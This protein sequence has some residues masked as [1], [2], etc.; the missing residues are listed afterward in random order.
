MKCRISELR[1]PRKLSHPTF[2]FSTRIGGYRFAQG[3]VANRAGPAPPW[4]TPTPSQRAFFQVA[5]SVVFQREV[6]LEKSG[7]YSLVL[8]LCCLGGHRRPNLIGIPVM[9]RPSPLH[10]SAL[11]LLLAPTEPPFSHL[12]S[13]PPLLLCQQLPFRLL[14]QEILKG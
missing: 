2:S 14:A 11:I 7:G 6:S 8:I 13:S 9:L 3:H 4:W 5:F 10:L 1:G 12:G